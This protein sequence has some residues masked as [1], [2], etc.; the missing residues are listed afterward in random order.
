V[1]AGG[2]DR[3]VTEMRT[4]IREFREHN[5]RVLNAMRE[6]LTDLRFHVDAGFTEIRGRL[7]AVDLGFIDIRG[8]LDGA[9]AGQEHIVGLLDTLIARDEGE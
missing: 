2:A 9:A 1:L 6:D 5:L 7:D 8:R 3:D 4:E